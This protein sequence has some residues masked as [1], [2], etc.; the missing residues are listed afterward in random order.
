[1]T[2]INKDNMFWILG[3]REV[4]LGDTVPKSDGGSV[5]DQAEDVEVG[6][7]SSIENCPSLR[8]GEPSR[9]GDHN[10]ADRSFEFSC[11][12]VS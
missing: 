7:L 12:G 11:G 10:I 2:D 6:N 1:M 8:I 4:R 5:V 3:I 9:N